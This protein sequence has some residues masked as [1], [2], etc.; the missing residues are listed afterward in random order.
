MCYIRQCFKEDFKVLLCFCSPDRDAP[1]HVKSSHVLQFFSIL[2]VCFR[3]RDTLITQVPYVKRSKRFLMCLLLS[4]AQR[5]GTAGVRQQGGGLALLTTG[6]ALARYLQKIP[7]V[8]RRRPLHVK[9]YSPLGGAGNHIDL[10]FTTHYCIMVNLGENL[11]NSL[12]AWEI[13]GLLFFLPDLLFELL[14]F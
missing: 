8:D 4:V 13:R 11:G 2:L 5:K 9:N 6:H 1:N 14:F 12:G 10:L 3:G 7:V